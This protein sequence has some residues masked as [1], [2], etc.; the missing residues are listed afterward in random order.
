LI[1]IGLLGA[2][3][4]A[5]TAVID[6]ARRLG[7]VEV[8]AVAASALEK[9]KAFAAEHEIAIAHQDYATLVADPGIDAVY[10]SVHPAAHARL[11]LAAL[12]V[13]RHVLIEKPMCLGAREASALENARGDLCVYEAVMSEH[14]WQTSLLDVAAAHE[15]GTLETVRS[16][17]RFDRTARMGYR[18]SRE[19]GGG[20]FLDCSPYWLQM[21]QAAIG[22]DV[23]QIEGSSRFDGPDGVDVEFNARLVYPNGVAATL[24]CALTG[25]MR[26]EHEFCFSAG[27]IRVR[28]FLRPAAGRFRV[29][30]LVTPVGGRAHVVG[31]DP[32]ASYDA[33]LAAFVA[34]IEGPPDRRASRFAAAVE[35]ARVA[36]RILTAARGEHR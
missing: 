1:R 3:A 30:L 35:R 7:L 29:N 31:F 5:R 26:A 36:E 20:G 18:A 2:T 22:L 12:A 33:Q 23:A 9:A 17:I 11:A 28:D 21:L 15:L 8:S 16:V 14:A 25:P 4:I 34:D 10:I 6:P 19:L 13:G 32:V 24:D 27:T